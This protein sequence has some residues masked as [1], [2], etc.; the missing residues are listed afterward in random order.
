MLPTASYCSLQF[1]SR[2]V[3]NLTISDKA[4]ETIIIEKQE[5]HQQNIHY[6]GLESTMKIHITSNIL[7]YQIIATLCLLGEEL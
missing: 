2:N 1:L 4:T 6:I 3:L 5:E 7:L